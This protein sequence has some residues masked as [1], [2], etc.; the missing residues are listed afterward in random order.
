MKNSTESKKQSCWWDVDVVCHC[1]SLECRHTGCSSAS[2][3]DSADMKQY[4][5]A[6]NGPTSVLTS[7]SN[8][9]PPMDLDVDDSVYCVSSPC[10]TVDNTNS[11]SVP[12]SMARDAVLNRSNAFRIMP[13]TNGVVP[14]SI[15]YRSTA[16]CQLC[17]DLREKCNVRL[18]PTVAE[19]AVWMPNCTDGSS[20]VSDLSPLSADQPI[21]NSAQLSNLSLDACCTN[22]LSDQS[23]S[24]SSP[25]V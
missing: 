11:R 20:R 21:D 24:S 8:S 5:M 9:L 12:S 4:P 16:S 17:H 13:P 2:E 22:S 7:A 18:L 23:S 14:P 15:S 6:V 10:D 25:E 1:R 19:Q 3:L